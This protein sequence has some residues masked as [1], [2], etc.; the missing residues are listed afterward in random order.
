MKLNTGPHSIGLIVIAF[1]ALSAL[2]V[3]SW[4]DT[5]PASPA[6]AAAP[7]AEPSGPDTAYA[8]GEA[9][10]DMEP[11]D[12]A[13]Q[14]PQVA[15]PPRPVARGGGTW[16]PLGPAPTQSAQVSVPPSNE[17]SG[18]IQAIAAHPTNADILYIGAVNGGIW[19]TTNATAAQPTWTPQ[20]DTLPSQSIG[21]LAF[22]PTDASRQTLIAGTGRF[23]NFAQ[24]GDDEIGVYRTTNGGATWTL[25]GGNTL[26]GQKIIA[27]AARGARL[28]AA[29]TTGGLFRSDNSGTTFALASGTGN[30]PTGGILDLVGNSANNNQLYIAVRGA[31][32]KVLRSDDG[33]LNWND[34]TTGIPSL[35]ASTG[36]LRLSVGAS[37]VVYAAVVNSG[38]LAAVVRSTNLGGTWTPMDVP[39]I[40]PGG[41]G[42]VNTS[43]VADPSNADLVYLGGDRITAS[44]FTGNV[45]RGNA[46][47]ATG[48]QFAIIHGSGGGNTSPH[49]DSRALAFDANGNLLESDD[50]GIYRRAT[51]ST[52]GTWGSVIGNLAVTE[53][54]DLAHDRVANVIMIGTQDNG[55]HMQQAAANP[56]WTMI[57]GG[58]GGDAAIDDDTLGI[59]GSYRYISSQNSGGFR[60][61]QYNAAN[62][63]VANQA[64]PAIADPQFVTPVE[65]NQVNSARMLVGGSNT[66]Y[67]STNITTGTPSF[68]SLGTPGA[69]RNAMAY[70]AADDANAAYVGKNAAVFRRQGA[71]FVATA[72]LPAGAAAITDVAMDPDDSLRVYAVDDNQVF[73]S[74]NGGTSWTDITGNLGTISAFDFRTI[75]YVPSPAGDTVVV[76]TR[77]GVFVAPANGSTWDLLGTG[78][79]DVLVFDLRYIATQG[80][81][82]A[83]TLGRGV[84][85][86]PFDN[87]R[88]FA[89]GFQ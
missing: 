52:T 29:S 69:N 54:H 3:T 88:I 68:T 36:A 37:G 28:F 87:D 67:E 10:G 40:H 48:S 64:L 77:S 78:L 72:A 2:A 76:G 7:S 11:V 34:V 70:G 24:R 46:S 81:L 79:P 21:A 14:R 1:A 9:D 17:V 66:V 60:R 5:G 41:Q 49:A 30:L 22:D 38:V 84:W 61:A 75:E 63:F 56:R 85:A 42:T 35:G 73:R 86:L 13:E 4:R 57:N 89:N 19:K 83:G 12:P 58:D 50:G 39:S 16:T 65:L 80:R 27:V 31:A 6:V 43:I 32:P 45:V 26:L 33:G 25:H 71:S 51:P 47:L 44:P 59:A 82:I 23:S 74:V 62:T 8:E 18:A 15:P 53:V 55:T 20:T